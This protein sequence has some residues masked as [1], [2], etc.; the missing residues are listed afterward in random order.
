MITLSDYFGPR[1]RHPEATDEMR[2]NATALLGK[3]NSL[4]ARADAEAGWHWPVDVDTGTCVSGSR[5]YS[6]DGGWRPS[7]A[8]TGAPRSSHKK[9][10]GID[11]YDP[12]NMLDDWLNDKILEEHG[13]Y[14]ETPRATNGWCHLQDVPPGSGRRTYDV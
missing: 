4:L 12:G 1:E 7:D 8:K 6:G 10:R 5:G 2:A 14:R 13:L 3:V 9:A 11:V